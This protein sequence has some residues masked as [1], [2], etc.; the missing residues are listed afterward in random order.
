MSRKVQKW[1]GLWIVDVPDANASVPLTV[2][3]FAIILATSELKHDLKDLW[4]G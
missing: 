1:S 2:T 4:C 3:V